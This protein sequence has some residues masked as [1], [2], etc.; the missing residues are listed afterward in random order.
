MTTKTALQTALLCQLVFLLSACITPTNK[1]TVVIRSIQDC[2]TCPRV[3]I[4]PP[5]TF[6]MGS[7]DDEPFRDA[8][9]GP[10]TPITIAKPFA[11]GRTEVTRGQFAA[12]VA[13]TGYEA[14]PRCMVWTGGKLEMVEGKSWRDPG[15]PQTDN[16][17][18]AC[19]SWTDAN[20]YVRWLSRTT[21]QVYRLPSNA[22]WEY[23]AR[24]G[25]L[26][27]YA[28]EGGENEACTYGNIGDESA[29]KAVPTWRT[30]ECDDGVGLGTAPVAN[31]KSNAYGLHDMVGNVWEWIADCYRPSYDGS[32]SDGS[33]WGAANQCGVA[34][35]RGGGFSNLIQGHLRV[36]NRSRAPSPDNPAYSL[37]FRVARDLT[38]TEIARAA[39]R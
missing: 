34:F 25:T 20:N 15:M 35:D 38:P 14:E 29:K 27:A 10:A 19:V 28:F 4:L 1:S 31:Y 6:I 5:G 26:S 17:P 12:F 11:L 3:M 8:D 7:P 13:A 2:P 18:V 22:E 24:G 33:A 37:G 16:H 9:E 32:P 39:T 36:A 23:G 30:A 21:G